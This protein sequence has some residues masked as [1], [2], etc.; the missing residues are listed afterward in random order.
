MTLMISYRGRDVG[1]WAAAFTAALP[2]MPIVA[3][4][5]VKDPLLVE[6]AVLWQHPHGDLARYPNLKAILS[7]GAGVEHIVSDPALPEG[8]PVVRLI[9]PAVVDDM[10]MHTLHWVLHFHRGY[11]RYAMQQR[12][13]RWQPLPAVAPSRRRIGI[14]GMGRIGMEIAQRLATLGFK[15]TGWGSEPLAPIDEIDYLCGEMH[16]EECLATSDI[17]INALPLTPETI[18]RIAMP[19]LAHLSPDTCVISISRGGI[20]DE[21]ALLEALDAGRLEAA[22]LDVFSEEPLPAEHPLWHHPG[23]Y[24]TPHI[25][26]INYPESAVQVMVESIRCIERGERPE[27]IYDPVRGY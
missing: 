25:G 12:E 7:L 22:A 20:I 1:P 21:C 4:P 8:V 23:V 15:V 14:L 26:G 2:G 17:L 27:S 3:Y 16:L 6:Y 18:G 11:H 24:I 5:E 10:A 9:D 19:E 13:T